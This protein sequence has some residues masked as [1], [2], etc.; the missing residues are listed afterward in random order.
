MD[1]KLLAVDVDGTLMNSCNQM[2]TATLHAL[3]RAYGAGMEIVLATGRM[4][5]EC[6]NPL[7]KMPFVRYAITCTGA[8]VQNLDTHEIIFR[9]TLTAD[10]LHLLCSRLWD[11][12]VMIQIFDDWDDKV[13]NDA[14]VLAEAERF[15]SL[16][17]AEAMRHCHHPERHFRKYVENYDGPTNK[18]HVLF[19][20]PED[21]DRVQAQLRDLPYTMVTTC[22]NDLEFMPLGVDKGSGLQL[23][24][25]H[26]DLTP[27]QVMAIG[28]G[29]NDAGMLRFAGF[30]VAMGNAPDSVKALAKRVTKD[31]DHDG[32]ASALDYLL[33]V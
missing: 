26:L 33:L 15:V 18:L 27:D 1:L 14:K 20:R 28:D 21:R 32:V 6:W 9:K 8:Q 5:S 22:A 12:D 10:D 30:P 11:L 13:H 3:E 19:A 4:L 24:C 29:E 17:Q 31:N 2:S 16:P 25:R 23:L 7:Y